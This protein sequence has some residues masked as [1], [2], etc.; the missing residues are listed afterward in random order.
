M[1]ARDEADIVEVAVRHALWHCDE[2]IA[3]DHLSVDGTREILEGLPVVLLDVTDRAFRGNLIWTWLATEA[4]VRGHEWLLVV[5]ADDIWHITAHP[6][7]R[8]ADWLAQQHPNDLVV[9][10]G[11][12]NHVPSAADDENERNP[13]LRIQWRDLS[14]DAMKVACRLR[15]ELTYADH[16]AWYGGQI[17]HPTVTRGLTVRHFTIRTADQLVRKVVN[18]LDGYSVA[19]GMEPGED[20][21]WNQWKGLSASQI[22]REFAARFYAADPAA[23]ERLVHDPAPLRRAE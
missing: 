2:V 20:A 11:S 19:A 16:N 1:V 9:S 14:P 8:I 13:V 3:A 5:D 17:W 15:P 21:G 18:G 6:N 22:R 7:D 12:F 4:R 23:D 10:A